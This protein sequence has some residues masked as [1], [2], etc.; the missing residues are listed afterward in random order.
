MLSSMKSSDVV[1]SGP[2]F[3]IECHIYTEDENESETS[4][5]EHEVEV[6]KL[7]LGES[8]QS[9]SNATNDARVSAGMGHVSKLPLGQLLSLLKL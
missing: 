3:I 8:R 5:Y 2:N 7:N 6:V 4:G 1:G 9:Q